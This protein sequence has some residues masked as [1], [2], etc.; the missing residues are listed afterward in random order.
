[1]KKYIKLF[2]FIATFFILSMIFLQNEVEGLT[3]YEGCSSFAPLCKTPLTSCQTT[4]D[5]IWKCGNNLDCTPDKKPI[6]CIFSDCKIVG[7]KK[8]CC[9]VPTT[10][11]TLRSGGIGTP[12]TSSDMCNE[13]LICVARTCVVNPTT[14]TKAINLAALCDAAHSQKV[15]QG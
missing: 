4:P 6:A 2:I 11:T 12:C 7:Y 5:P 8:K 9:T 14:T 15:A 13:G 10:T 3:C 1:M